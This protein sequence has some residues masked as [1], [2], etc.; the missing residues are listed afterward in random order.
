MADALDEASLFAGL[1]DEAMAALKRIAVPFS[2]APGDVLFRQ[3]DPPTGLYVVGR[4]L[5]EIATRLPGD[6][7]AKFSGI[8]AGEVVGEFALLD[9]GPRSARV[10]ALEQAEG[11]F[12]PARS[13]M[14]M[15]DE[16]R[17]GGVEAIDR[18][19]GL[20][21]RRTRETLDRLREAQ[22]ADPEELRKAAAATAITTTRLDFEMVRSLGRYAPFGDTEGE[23]FLSQGEGLVLE[24]GNRLA[25][26]G[27]QPDLVYLVVRGA[28][29]A[30]FDRG[31][32]EEQ[33][34]VHG[35]GEWAGL[36]EAVD[37]GPRPLTLSAAEDS[38]LWQV[39]VGALER[40]RAGPGGMELAAL[41]GIDRQLVKDQR[42]ANRHL[43][44]AIALDRFNAMGEA[45]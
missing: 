6:E 30:A 11:Q 40:W 32:A 10:V 4:G 7:E 37:P 41:A 31:G 1:S 39:P 22:T 21:A 2:A 45:A 24:R 3:G 9:P 44:R 29:R 20:V 25:E 43:G 38:L 15:V 26:A 13:F 18:V 28:V 14:A 33:L 35:P 12:L 36:V 27:R 19:R 23:V 8:G 16:G 42:R 17:S 34:T 5:L